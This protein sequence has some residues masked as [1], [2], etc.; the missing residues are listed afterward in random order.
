VLSLSHPLTSHPLPT[1]RRQRASTELNREQPI[2]GGFFL[3]DPASAD[4]RS[5]PSRSLSQVT[6]LGCT[7]AFQ[8]GRFPANLPVS[9]KCRTAAQ[10]SLDRLSGSGRRSLHRRRPSPCHRAWGDSP[11]KGYEDRI[12]L[13]VR[14]ATGEHFVGQVGSVD[15]VYQS[16]R[17]GFCGLSEERHLVGLGDRQV[18]NGT[19]V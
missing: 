8:N 19:L 6:V 4:L 3:R 9:A 7:R 16:L 18:L 13:V 12:F 10:A 5:I 17:I 1:N 15:G 14:G 11:E 2:Y